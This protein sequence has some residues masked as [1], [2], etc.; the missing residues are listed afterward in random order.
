MKENM[1]RT[2]RAGGASMKAVIRYR[3]LAGNPQGR[4]DGIELSALKGAA[5]PFGMR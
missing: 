3:D 1:T 5:R 2:R 4:G